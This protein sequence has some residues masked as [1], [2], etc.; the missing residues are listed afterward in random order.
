MT[1]SFDLIYTRNRVEKTMRCAIKIGALVEIVGPFPADACAV[2][3]VNEIM[4]RPELGYTDRDHAKNAY[5]AT[6]F[7]NMSRGQ[8]NAGQDYPDRKENDQ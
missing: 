4:A 7:R 3:I 5:M 6:H 1:A 8:N 2:P